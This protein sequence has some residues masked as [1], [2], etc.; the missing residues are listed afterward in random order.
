MSTDQSRQQLMPTS[1]ALL[2]ALSELT[3][4]Y[5]YCMRIEPDGTLERE[6]LTAG[7]TSVTGYELEDLDGLGGWHNL[8]HPEDLPAAIEGHTRI[9]TDPN[10]DREVSEFRIKT[11]G[12]ETRRLRAYARVVRDA[13]TGAPRRIVGAVQDITDWWI[14]EE[15]RKEAHLALETTDGLRQRLLVHLMKARE[16][17]RRHVASEIHDDTIQV[18][19]SV[20]IHL[21]R[22]SG[23]LWGKGERDLVRGLELSVRDALA[24]LRKMVFE[25]RP[26]V[27]EHEGLVAAL[28][29]L[30]EDAR[31]HHGLTFSIKRQLPKE[32]QPRI[33]DGLYRI[34]HEALTN[35]I[36][37]AQATRVD[38][39]FSYENDGFALQIVDDGV[40]FSATTATSP[41]GHLGMTEMTE[42]AHGMGGW[43]RIQSAPDN[44]T[45]VEFWLPDR[46]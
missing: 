36:K 21:E 41:P 35:I 28:T 30:L 38:L 9:L 22:L 26:P 15:T 40:G 19:A 16:D 44:G 17:E 25:L 37:H 31:I 29:M 27:L 1:E 24:R 10:L 18:M 2:E 12:G 42:L 33:R 46:D 34:G 3:S 23:K 45:T 5:A 43:L 11:K 7:F 39:N 14:A 6:W 8:I 13:D 20:A 4:D 32:P